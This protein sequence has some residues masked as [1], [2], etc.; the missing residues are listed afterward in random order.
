MEL[1]EW[2]HKYVAD[3]KMQ[4]ELNKWDLEIAENKGYEQGV[5]EGIEQGIE[6]GVEQNKN[7]NVPIN[8][9]T[10]R[11]RYPI[12]WTYQ[13]GIETLIVDTKIWVF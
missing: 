12:K 1:N 5:I 8:V 11:R 13:E 2:I 7:Y 3:D 6:Q 9:D 4:D 10:I